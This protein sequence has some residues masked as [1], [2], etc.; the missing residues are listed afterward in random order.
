MTDF[1]V[2][3][4]VLTAGAA[5]TVIDVRVRRVPNVVTMSVA[6]VGLLLAMS[7]RGD[8]TLGAALAG[9]AVGLAVMLPG[10]VLGATGAGDV[11]LVAAFGTLLGPLDI[12][13]AFIRMA[14][15]GGVIALIV[16]LVRGRLRESVNGTALLVMSGGRAGAMISDPAVNNRFPFA[17]AI[18]IGAALMVLGW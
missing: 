5:A 14:I 2:P 16:A 4:I 12:L 1:I 17:P 11:K 18:A 10:H 7:G 8:I 15:A 13:G 6:S 9:L 3:A